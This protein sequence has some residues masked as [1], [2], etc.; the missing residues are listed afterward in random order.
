MSLYLY[1]ETPKTDNTSIFFSHNNVKGTPNPL[2]Y[3]FPTG[4]YAKV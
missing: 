1:S 3:H 2:L 4:S